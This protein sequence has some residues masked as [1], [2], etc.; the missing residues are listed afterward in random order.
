MYQG[1]HRSGAFHGVGQPNVQ[2]VHGRLAG[3]AYEY[4]GERPGYGRATHEG[5]RARS[6]GRLRIVEQAGHHIVARVFE[7]VECAC[8]VAYHNHAQQEEEVGQAGDDESL[9]RGMNGCWRSVVEA[10]EQVGRNAHHLK[11]DKHLENIGR[12]HQT[13]H[14]EREELQ[15]GVVALEALFGLAGL[16]AH[17]ANAEQVHQKRNCR[18]HDEHHG[19]DG[20][21]EH[22][23][24]CHQL[25]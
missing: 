8:V 13:Q 1:R 17:V 16:V 15:E 9:L 7:E 25:A 18:H 3:T 2:G 12:N 19:R 4:H 24:A 20:V 11:E 23:Q 10:N 22:A 21:D 14:R 6:D 5:A